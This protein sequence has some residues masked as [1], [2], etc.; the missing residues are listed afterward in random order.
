VSPLFGELA[1]MPPL[2]LQA[3]SREMLRDDSLRFAAA[4]RVAGVEIEC[5]VW[6]GMQHVFPLLQFLPES[7]RAIDAVARF[8]G[9]WTGWN[10][11]AVDDALTLLRAA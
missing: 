8:V 2:L 6:P 3:G 10:A 11:P 4:A 1:G 5:E 9:R 7:E